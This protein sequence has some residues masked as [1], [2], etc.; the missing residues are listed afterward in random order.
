MAPVS[1]TGIPGM[2]GPPNVISAPEMVATP[3][4]TITPQIS[5]APT[6]R[7]TPGI[8]TTPATTAAPEVNTA[9]KA[10]IIPEITVPEVT[11][12]PGIASAQIARARLARAP[13]VTVQSGPTPREKRRDECLDLLATGLFLDPKKGFLRQYI[14]Y[15]V[16]PVYKEA[17]KARR[18]ELRQRKAGTLRLHI[19]CPKLILS[20]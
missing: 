17:V 18:E 14:S 11:D 8:R 7:A 20:S 15:I 1:F 13:E 12:V 16:A 9:P 5:T 2:A 19:P 10:N 6:V 3:E 4:I